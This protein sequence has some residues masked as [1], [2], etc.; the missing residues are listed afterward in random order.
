MDRCNQ[1]YMGEF[2]KFSQIPGEEGFGF[3]CHLKL[4][5]Q[6]QLEVAFFTVS[7]KM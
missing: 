6:F 5:L 7:S 1:P 3:D 2:P 4:A